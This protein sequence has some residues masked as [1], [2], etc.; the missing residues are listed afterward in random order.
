M[1]LIFSGIGLLYIAYRAAGKRSVNATGVGVTLLLAWYWIRAGAKAVWLAVQLW[2]QTTVTAVGLTL[3][4]SWF[5]LQARIATIF[6]DTRTTLVIL[7]L[8]SV[9]LTIGAGFRLW[10]LL[11]HTE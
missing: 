5:N 4:T 9:T 10:L 1:E 7:L 3:V 11:R 8:L 2:V 6:V